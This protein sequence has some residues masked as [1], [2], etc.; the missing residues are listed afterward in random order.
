MII[1]IVMFIAAL[2]NIIYIGIF[3]RINAINELFI[4]IVCQLC[5]FTSNFIIKPPDVDIDQAPQTDE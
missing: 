3:W 2:A 5:I 1:L 4:L